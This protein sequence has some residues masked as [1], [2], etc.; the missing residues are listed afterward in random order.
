M[1]ALGAQQA[2]SKRQPEGL[3]SCHW[4]AVRGRRV[5]PH[6]FR[7]GDTGTSR[8]GR[9]PTPAVGIAPREGG[10]TCLSRAH[11]C[12]VGGLTPASQRSAGTRKVVRSGATTARSP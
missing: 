9:A 1:S 8:S 11:V 6:Y 4:V 10:N 3:D 2:F 12:H 7:E 5:Q